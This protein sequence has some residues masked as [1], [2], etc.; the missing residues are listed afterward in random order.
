ML[1]WT[2]LVL[3]CG[4]RPTTFAA[5]QDASCKR[6][7]AL[8]LWHDDREGLRRELSG[9][10]DPVE[11]VALVEALT[12]KYPGETATL[13]EMLQAGAGKERCERINIRPHLASGN[14]SASTT[15]NTTSGQQSTSVS[16]VDLTTDTIVQGPGMTVLIP[17]DASAFASSPWDSVSAREVDCDGVATERACRAQAAQG[18]ASAGKADLAGAS[19]A[20]IDAGQW[21]WEC[22]FNA[23][24][25]ASN[26]GGGAVARAAY[27][28]CLGTG[29]FM[30][31]CFAHA[32]MGLANAAPPSNTS[33][34][35]AWAIIADAAA[36]I[37]AVLGPRDHD[38]SNRVIERLWS[39]AMQTSYKRMS[40]VSGDPLDAVPDWVQP[41]VRA[42]AAQQLITLEWDQNRSF[43]EWGKLLEDAL[44]LRLNGGGNAISV[45]RGQPVK[46]LWFDLLPGESAFT[47]VLYL[48]QARR[49]V[50]PTADDDRLICI[51]EAIGRNGS[52]PAQIFLDAL[53]HPTREVRWTAARII[54]NL[55]TEGSYLA[56]VRANPDPVVA[57]RGVPM[58]MGG[59]G[60]PSMGGPGGPGGAMFPGATGGQPPN[61]P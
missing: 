44:S 11:Q 27:E 10:S 61:G 19:C 48:G 24:E 30:A 21:R 60:G 32:A 58:A 7:V 45:T 34:P 42:A 55:D 25:A 33:D 51:L 46:N 28:L 15:V 14:T 8:R 35:S 38:L 6:E 22:M 31:N 41:H 54:Q 47:R 40:V 4:G 59:S 9:V 49:V 57:G 20:G 2:L 17:S 1:L 39:E 52:R 29:D 13:C 37:D 18:Y 23:A 26:V 12:E 50:G 53:N 43:A 5:C 56:Q 16:A 36:A 3:A